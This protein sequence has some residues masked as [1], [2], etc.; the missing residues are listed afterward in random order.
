MTADLAA[1]P[2]L[3]VVIAGPSGVGKGTVWARVMEQLPDA[4]F[5][6]S[7]TTRSPRPGER[8]AIDYHFVSGDEFERLIAERALLEWAE[9]AGNR[10]GTPLAPVADA[11]AAGRV[12]ILD[13]ELQG[14]IQ[15]R[16]RDP[17][18]LLIL[19][20]PPSMDELERRLR[21]R[22]TDA[23]DGIRQRLRTATRELAQRDRF[24]CVVV[25]DDLDRTVDEVLATI[26]AARATR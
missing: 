19:L 4:R 2:G 22:G 18:A 20:V 21:G 25:N 11:V 13:I 3:L 12:V 16:E 15:V 5:S 17:E 10:Y 23:E 9:Y 1:A 6:V 14:A 7:A 26:A 8:E 24:D